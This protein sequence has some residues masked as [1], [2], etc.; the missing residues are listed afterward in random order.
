MPQRRYRF[1]WYR[2][3]IWSMLGFFAYVFIS[4]QIEL[5]TIQREIDI[6]QTQLKQ[7]T[8]VHEALTTERQQLTTP[9][10]IEKLAREQLGLVKPG[11]VPYIPAGNN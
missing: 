2:L 3:I 1:S 11:E 9:A 6:T 4:Q 8:E 5:Q 10:Y 7:A